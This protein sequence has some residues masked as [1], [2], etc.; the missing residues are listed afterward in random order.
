MK[1]QHTLAVHNMMLYGIVVRVERKESTDSLHY[2]LIS[3]KKTPSPKADDV[4]RNTIFLRF[5]LMEND[6]LNCIKICRKRREV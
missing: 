2:N 6:K 5:S 3:W 4:C 1:E